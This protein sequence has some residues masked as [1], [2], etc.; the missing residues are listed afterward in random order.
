MPLVDLANPAELDEL[1]FNTWN[2]VFGTPR[3][4]DRYGR[5]VESNVA[6]SAG[7]GAFVAPAILER[8]YNAYYGAPGYYVDA[9]GVDRVIDDQYVE[10][11]YPPAI[12]VNPWDHIFGTFGAGDPVEY[13][14][15]VHAR[16]RPV[17]AGAY[18]FS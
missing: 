15:R 12:S 16:L 17:Q 13:M 2:S 3:V 14:Q 9:R 18:S 5:F 10:D 1:I 4:L 8:G 11:M 6:V 7:P